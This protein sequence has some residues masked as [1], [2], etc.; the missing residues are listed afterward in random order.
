[1]VALRSRVIVLFAAFLCVSCGLESEVF[2]P[3][4]D[5]GH[6][7][8]PEPSDTLLLGRAS[9]VAG[10]KVS[11]YT[12]SGQF[13]A[14]SV[15]DQEGDFTLRFSGASEHHGLVLWA[16]H[17]EHVVVGILP[18]LPKQPTVFHEE[19]Y[20]FA[21]D[22][23]PL[24]NDLNE[25]STALSM[26]VW[27]SSLQGGVSLDAL[28]SEAIRQGLDEAQ[29]LLAS[30]NESVKAFYSL[31]TILGSLAS[32]ATGPESLYLSSALGGGTSLLSSE[33][34]NSATLPDG[35]AGLTPDWFD[36]RLESAASQVEIGIC[37][38][39]DRIRVVFRVDLTETKIN[40]NCAVVDPF[41]WASNEEGKSVFF[42]GGIHEDTPVCGAERQ[43]HCLSDDQ[44]DEAHMALGSWVPNQLVMVD[45]G[46]Q[47]DRLAGDGIWAFT[48]EL[49]YIDTN[50]SP[51]GAGVR[52]GY[53]Y[54]FGLPGQGWTDSQE[55][56]GNQRILELAD[57]NGDQLVLR[58]DIFG[59]EAANK[60]K[61]NALAP[62][63]GG[64]GVIA[65]PAE[66]LPNCATDTRENRI[67]S[68]SDCVAD[69]WPNA[70]PAVPLTT[71]CP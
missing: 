58:T 54:T 46:T 44:V 42:S 51:D 64:C 37:Y 48:V 70:A 26:L 23:H 5:K 31:V 3:I 19:R 60:D 55:W 8:L 1:M 2:G 18:E 10:G 17:G 7:Q 25:T 34:L 52:I 63:K 67:D 43:T 32:K 45:D 22:Q 14:D 27:K 62:A 47:G 11:A 39:D 20:V 9:S 56:P 6:V 68:D 24:L 69:A 28:S 13:V 30:E 33:W 53:K 57:E 38:P 29:A 16:S 61:V 4:L 59:D 40:A 35:L 36:E 21:W 15:V 49:P 71:Q 65:W 41:K 50:A 66:A 12:A